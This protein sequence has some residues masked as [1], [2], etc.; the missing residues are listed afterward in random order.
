MEVVEYSS[1]PILYIRSRDNRNGVLVKLRGKFRAA[2]GIFEGGNA[3]CDCLNG[4][5]VM[6]L[7]IRIDG[8]TLARFQQMGVGFMQRLAKLE[9]CS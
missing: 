4:L 2:L 3:W 6:I 5:L 7:A 1:T 8:Q 9:V